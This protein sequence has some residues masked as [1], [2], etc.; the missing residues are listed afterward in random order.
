MSRKVF[1]FVLT[2]L[3][4][5]PLFNS[6]GPRAIAAAPIEDHPAQII[7]DLTK[8]HLENYEA[9]GDVGVPLAQQLHNRLQQTLN[10]LEKGSAEQA[11]K[12]MEDFLKH[13]HNEAMEITVAA[14]EQ[15]DADAHHVIRSLGS[16]SLEPLTLVEDGEANAV[17]IVPETSGEHVI[18]GWDRVGRDVINKVRLVDS[19]SYSGHR[20]LHID[21]DNNLAMGLISNHVSI[22]GG[23]SYTASAMTYIESGS[24]PV[25]YIQYF[26]QSKRMIKSSFASFNVKEVWTRIS[27]TLAAPEEAAFAAVYLN[28]DSTG[29]RS[30]YF[31]DAELKKEGSESNL[32]K[33]PGFEQISSAL[34][35]P[36]VDYVQKSAGVELQV[37]N[38]VPTDYDGVKIYISTSRPADDELHQAL[39]Q[40]LNEHGFIIDTQENAITIRGTTPRATEYGVDEFLERY[41]GVRWLMP[42]PDGEHVPQHTKITVPSELVRIQPA[43]ISRHFFG[44]AGSANQKWA[45]QNR[46]HHNIQFHHNMSTLFDPKVFA[47]HPEYYAGGVVPTHP[48]SWQP[49][50]NNVTAEAATQ[51]IIEYFNANPEASSYSLGINDGTNYCENI[52]HPDFP[53]QTNSVGKLNRSDVY[54]RWVNKIAEGVLEVHPDKYFGLLAYR[55][56]YDPPMNPDG[57]L[58]KLNAHVVPYITDDRMSWADLL[59]GTA[60]M[61]HTERWQQAAT[62]LGFY[63]YMYG[64]LYNV[65]RVYIHKMAENYQYGQEHG[66]IGH[67][68]ELYPNWGEGPKPWVSAKLQWNPDQNVDQLLN[69][70]Y[71]SAVGEEAAPYLQQYYEYWEQFWTTRIFTSDWYREW[72][73][74]SVRN[75]YLPFIDQRYLSMVTKEDITVSRQLLEQAVA[76][77]A[78]DKQRIR[79]ELLLRSYEFYEAS[80]LS[81]SRSESVQPPA[82][83]QAALEMLNDIRTSLEMA[84]K[85]ERLLEEFT[86]HPI[87]D[88]HGYSRGEWNGVQLFLFNALNSYVETEPDNGPVGVL[89]N[90]F[91]AE[92]PEELRRQF[93]NEVPD[94]PN[95]SANAV[96]TTATKSEIMQSLEFGTGPWTDAQPFNEFLV[97]KTT[98]ISPVETKVYLLWDDENLYVG[99]ENYDSDLTKM[100]VSDTAPNGWW[101][102]N[103]DDSVETY[104]T[105]DPEGSFYGF[106]TNPKA[107]NFTYLKNPD[108]GPVHVTGTGLTSSARISSDRWNVI[109][110]IPF[111]TI[112]VDPNETDTLSGFF[113]R[114]YHGQSVYLGWGGGAP[115]KPT[116]FKP[117]HLVE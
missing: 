104:V 33:N 86:G 47:D 109:Q 38:S 82:N 45:Q 79:A 94:L 96:K 71:V 41:V 10:H 14:K 32:L 84:E 83:E 91:L 44:M 93:L 114:N 65:P 53:D 28:S 54:Y 57:T 11:A 98:N 85:R 73:D 39:L 19:R 72:A 29:I 34:A 50:F 80:A 49:C 117:I 25:L 112:G 77:T 9:S 36:L 30:V 20:S 81:Y 22:T 102:S 15:L 4:A 35:A 12:M 63:D 55:E 76:N 87:L 108:S 48:Y 7:A 113:F 40:D 26:D 95:L 67:V 17:I 58:Y 51:R 21:D 23:E 16:S 105:G 62:S 13:L 64:A 100:V 92:L 110:V 115:W 66:V 106:F 1:L 42:G 97:M 5:L 46:M 111:S 59:I 31:D 74:D 88:L 61:Q 37:M 68:A 116:D 3:I 6:T 89:V 56:M 43:T 103:A 107:V 24:Y 78:T 70:W 60:G 8:T 18:S 75:N 90:Q 52:G 101:A 99:Y 27:I 2:F 69:D